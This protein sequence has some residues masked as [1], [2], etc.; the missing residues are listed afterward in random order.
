MTVS[1]DDGGIIFNSS[2]FKEGD[3]IYITIKS[4]YFYD[5]NIYYEFVDDLFIYNPS[6]SFENLL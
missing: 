5:S 2:D 3:E 6:I 1:W 4:E